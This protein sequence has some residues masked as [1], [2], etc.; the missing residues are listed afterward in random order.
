MFLRAH[1]LDPWQSYVFRKHFKKENAANFWVPLKFLYIK[2]Q[3]EDEVKEKYVTK[4]KEYCDCM[5]ITSNIL[6]IIFAIVTLPPIKNVCL[7]SVKKKQLFVMSVICHWSQCH[8]P[9]PGYYT[10]REEGDFGHCIW[11]CVS[12]ILNLSS[13][14]E[15]S[16]LYSF[17][18]SKQL[19]WLKFNI[20]RN[21]MKYWTQ[22]SKQSD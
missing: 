10:G 9:K 8:C 5:F 16:S 3:K 14:R 15:I 12:V 22:N 4:C 2:N 13:C 11:K 20:N 21:Y 17:W 7:L 6:I 18:M 1:S 19:V